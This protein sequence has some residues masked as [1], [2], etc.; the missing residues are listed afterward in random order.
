MKCFTTWNFIHFIDWWKL[1]WSII[2]IKRAR[3]TTTFIKVHS[4]SEITLIIHVAI[5]SKNLNVV[6]IGCFTVIG[7]VF[8]CTK[9]QCPYTRRC[10]ICSDSSTRNYNGKKFI[11]KPL[12][13]IKIHA[14]VVKVSHASL[15]QIA[16]FACFLLRLPLMYHNVG[17]ITYQIHSPSM[18]TL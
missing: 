3:N 13:S 10:M 4:C 16:I 5:F 17:N 14:V 12:Q 15:T 6:K 18:S 9:R 1:I 8:I 2:E 11:L 7:T